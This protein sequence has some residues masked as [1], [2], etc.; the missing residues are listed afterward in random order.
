MDRRVDAEASG[1]TFGHHAPVVDDDDRV[2]ASHGLAIRLGKGAVERRLQACLVR[3][4]DL[5]PRD[6]G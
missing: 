5:R 6:V 4:D 3:R 2:G 1:I